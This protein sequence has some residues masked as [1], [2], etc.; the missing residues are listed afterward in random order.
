MIFESA[1]SF[2]DS[3]ELAYSVLVLIQE[4]V[5]IEEAIIVVFVLAELGLCD[6]GV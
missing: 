5:V 2:K 4:L 1:D 3:I 6:V